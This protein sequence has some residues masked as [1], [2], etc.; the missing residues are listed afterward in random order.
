MLSK[1]KYDSLIL[2]IKREIFAVLII[3]NNNK[4]RTQL[5]SF[6]HISTVSIN[7]LR[8]V[9][10]FLVIEVYFIMWIDQLFDFNSLQA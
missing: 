9:L 6:F 7:W 5:V 8:L 4:F 1:L 3:K 2:T 10:P